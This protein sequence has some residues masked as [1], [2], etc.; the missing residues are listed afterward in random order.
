MRQNRKILENHKIP[1]LE[2]IIQNLDNFIKQ[3]EVKI[4]GPSVI[5][6]SN[7]SLEQRVIRL[8]KT[9]KIVGI[10]DLS[11]VDRIARLRTTLETYGYM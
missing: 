2:Q 10:S 4:Y 6:N 11:L 5:V 1:K 3:I 7:M 8:E 9:L